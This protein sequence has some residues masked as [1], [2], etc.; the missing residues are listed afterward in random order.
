MRTGK[1]V[2]RVTR[3]SGNNSSNPA[4]PDGHGASESATQPSTSAAQS[5]TSYI[6][7]EPETSNA[8]PGPS[9]R[10][11]PIPQSAVYQDVLVKCNALVEEYRKEKMSKP[12]VYS[13]I[14]AKLACSLEEDAERI[15]AAFGSFIATVES[16]DLETAMAARRGTR[17]GER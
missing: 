6:E 13:K 3:S 17:A 12:T 16:H 10:A 8:V 1:N 5:S 2:Q 11:S 9:L 4:V 15:N 7:P 14:R